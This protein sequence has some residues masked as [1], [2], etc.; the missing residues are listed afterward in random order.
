MSSAPSVGEDPAQPGD[1]LASGR[2]RLAANGRNNRLQRSLGNIRWSK[3]ETGIKNSE[4]R[5]MQNHRPSQKS[6]GFTLVRRPLVPELA[7]VAEQH[8]ETRVTWHDTASAQ[9]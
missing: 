6:I 4:P 3:G 8:R 7:N 9:P 5:G 2:I 1:T